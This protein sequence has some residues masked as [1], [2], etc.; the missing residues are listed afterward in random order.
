MIVSSETEEADP[1][2]PV[3]SGPA[4]L[5]AKLSPPMS[6]A[7]DEAKLPTENDV[8]KSVRGSSASKTDL[9]RAL[10]AR[11]ISGRALRPA[12]GGWP[13]AFKRRWNKN[14]GVLLIGGL[15]TRLVREKELPLARFSCSAGAMGGHGVYTLTPLKFFA[16]DLR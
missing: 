10:R 14:M 3:P 9:C 2:P 15:R 11:R 8:V 13:K 12:A 7:P 1:G 5:G 4:T 6:M 16:M